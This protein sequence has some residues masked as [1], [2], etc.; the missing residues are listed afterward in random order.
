MRVYDRRFESSFSV[1]L[2][3]TRGPQFDDSHRRRL[4]STLVLRLC[5]ARR[6][7]ACRRVRCRRLDCNSLF[8]SA[9]KSADKSKKLTNSLLSFHPLVTAK[10]TRLS[11]KLRAHDAARMRKAARLVA[12]AAARSRLVV[13]V[14]V[15]VI[16]AAIAPTRRLRVR[17]RRRRRYVDTH[18]KHKRAI[19]LERLAIATSGV[20]AT[21]M[22]LQAA[23]ASDFLFRRYSAVRLPLARSSF[24]LS[25][26]AAIRALAPA[27]ASKIISCIFAQFFLLFEY[28]VC[29]FE[30]FCNSHVKDFIL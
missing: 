6:R 3:S 26:S 17:T 11:A 27:S 21:F 9:C 10:T 29:E 4:A 25:I 14:V 28:F 15:V 19:R 8:L 18:D 1:R 24:T 23:N 22:S 13:D 20:I 16:T 7:F 12:I 2:V 30:T 5:G